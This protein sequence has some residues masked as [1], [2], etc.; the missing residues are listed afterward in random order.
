L[1]RASAH[2]IMLFILTQSSE[3]RALLSQLNRLSN[4][5][6]SILLDADLDLD[7]D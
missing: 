3:N 4:V 2:V 6:E 7:L 5:A 1:S